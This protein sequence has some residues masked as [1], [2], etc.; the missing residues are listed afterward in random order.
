MQIFEWMT[1]SKWSRQTWNMRNINYYV[2]KS[3][4]FYFILHSSYMQYAP[5]FS[6]KSQTSR[7]RNNKSSLKLMPPNTVVAQLS[8]FSLLKWCF[9]VSNNYYSF[10]ISETGKYSQF[11]YFGAPEAWCSEHQAWSI[12]AYSSFEIQTNYSFLF[13]YITVNSKP[14]SGNN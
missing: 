4:T 10:I 14:S 5:L 2:N 3:V 12:S 6:T 13:F 11:H 7:T 1:F 8:P 9:Y